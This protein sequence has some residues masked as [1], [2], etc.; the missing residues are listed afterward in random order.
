MFHGSILS[1]ISS[2]GSNLA[3]RGKRTLS[4]LFKPAPAGFNVSQPPPAPPKPAMPSIGS[5]QMFSIGAGG[6][7]GTTQTPLQFQSK[8]QQPFTPAK[9]S[10]PFAPGA[11]AGIQT[12]LGGISKTLGQL[13]TS[14]AKPELPLV[15]PNK[16]YFGE[17]GKTPVTLAVEDKT[18][19]SR[20]KLLDILLAKAET[21]FDYKAAFKGAREEAG[22]PE[23]ET[24][25]GKFV[26][27]TTDVESLLDNLEKDIMERNKDFMVTDP[28]RRRQLAAEREPL[29]KQL[30]V[31]E[32]GLRT[33]E[34]AL[35]PRQKFAE[36]LLTSQQAGRK[37]QMDA[38]IAAANMGD[39]EADRAL[40]I[41][42]A[43]LEA[44]FKEQELGFKE[45]EV[46]LK[47]EAA[48]FEIEKT[49]S[50]IRK[51]LA[52]ADSPEKK[53][54]ELDKLVSEIN[55]NESATSLNYQKASR[56][57][58]GR[59]LPAQRADFFAASQSS[60]DSLNQLESLLAEISTGPVAGVS[61]WARRGTGTES[62]AR[63]A[64]NS[65]AKNLADQILR[66]RSGAQTGEKEL[67]RMSDFL[68]DVGH[69]EGVNKENI[70]QLRTIIKRV[71]NLNADIMRQSG[72]NVPEL[73][74]T[75]GEDMDTLIQMLQDAG[76]IPVD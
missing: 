6:Q 7:V 50:E 61:A 3:Q 69:Q 32:R 43:N 25:K 53:Q 26:K 59:P 68:P 51:N 71:I 35:E 47:E 49:L 73:A 12:S 4:D 60:L 31:A 57:G 18:K 11:L 19:S 22:V 24:L 21:P 10:S 62:S 46:G 66:V 48:P 37:E 30:S 8:P 76:A 39:K 67:E 36:G 29:S 72:Y 41:A 34:A 42:K 5:G 2:V 38:L 65:L 13:G 56:A 64:F 20:D 45:R 55:K 54:L 16:D 15:N 52:S 44:G 75:G 17:S 74:Q 58:G 63:I 1:S 27:Q 40:Q 33:T 23:L 9:P 14:L 28:Q 70:N